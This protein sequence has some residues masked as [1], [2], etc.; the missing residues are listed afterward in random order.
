MPSTNSPITPLEA[1]SAAMR[2]NVLGETVSDEAENANA[3]QG[4][5]AALTAD[6]DD[7]P[8]FR[9][10]STETPTVVEDQP[11]EQLS[12]SA[13]AAA[14]PTTPPNAD[15]SDFIEVSGLLEYDP[16][17]ISRIYAGAPQRLIRR[18]WQTLVPI[19]LYLLSVGIDWLTRRLANHDHARARA[20]EAADLVASLGPAFIKAGQ[21]LS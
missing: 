8:A 21:A 10:D 19:G 9:T 3:D 16:A 5:I 6:Q 13:E 7:H 2:R 11:S 14:I 12:R 20:K 1:A 4:E 18:I 15:L 17:A